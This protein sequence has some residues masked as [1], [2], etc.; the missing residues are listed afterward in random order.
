MKNLLFTTPSCPNC[1]TAK[2]LLD[3]KGIEYNIVDASKPEGLEKAK[4][5][6]VGSV[7]TLIILDDQ[8][9]FKDS[10]RSVDEIEAYILSQ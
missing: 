2:S 8:N 1:P 10:A 5:F 7:P 3:I 9:K 4:K 6:G